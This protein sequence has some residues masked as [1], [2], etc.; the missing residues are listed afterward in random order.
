MPSKEYQ[1]II[2]VFAESKETAADVATEM[3]N[4][5]AE[6]DAVID[7][8]EISVEDGCTMTRPLRTYGY[9]VILWT[10]EELKDADPRRLEDRSIELGQDII[11]D[12]Q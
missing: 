8:S 10:P 5:G 9:A 3:L 11:E 4:G 2:N 1:V 12:L 7:L 6:P